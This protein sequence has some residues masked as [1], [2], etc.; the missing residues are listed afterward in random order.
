MRYCIFDDK[1]FDSNYPDGVDRAEYVSQGH[2]NMDEAEGFTG[3]L[4][5]LRESMESCQKQHNAKLLI[6]LDLSLAS[7][8]NPSS[9]V[10]KL[11]DLYTDSHSRK[12]PFDGYDLAIS[13]DFSMHAPIFA[14]EE[15]DFV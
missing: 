7:G 4:L 5:S 3:N 13:S 11:H 9:L 15:P 2:I 6:N 10:D 8:S 12:L 14:Q 1:I